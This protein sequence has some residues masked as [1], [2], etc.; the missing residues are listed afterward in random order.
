ML[1]ERFGEY[2]ARVRSALADA[3]SESHPPHDVAASFAFGVFV[4]ALPTLG[5]GFAVFVVVAYLSDRVSK[6]ALLASVVLGE[7]AV[8][9][10][11]TL[12]YRYETTAG[13]TI[14]LVA[15]GIYVLAVLAGKLRTGR[16]EPPKA[17]AD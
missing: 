3:F 7:L 13:G 1:R 12:S 2:R 8:L 5:T 15:V 11:I 4:T 9:V 16:E 6:L 14:V 10:G 17:P